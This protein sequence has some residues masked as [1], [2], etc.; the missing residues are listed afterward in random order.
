MRTPM[1]FIEWTFVYLFAVL[2]LGLTVAIALCII[3]GYKEIIKD[4]K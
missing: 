2:A 3:A 1:V 4:K